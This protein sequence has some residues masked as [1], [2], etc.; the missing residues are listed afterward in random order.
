VDAALVAAAHARCFDIH[1]YTVNTTAEIASLI[2]LGVDDVFT[3]FPDRLDAVLAKEAVG[4]KH[5]ASLAADAHKAC[6]GA[7]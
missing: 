7:Q 1:P 5:A 3:N 2:A 6:V 4:G